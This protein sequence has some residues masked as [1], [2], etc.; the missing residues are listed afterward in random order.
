MTPQ[1]TQPDL[2]LTGV[3]KAA[4]FL[5][6]IG[7]QISADV[8]RRLSPEEI[9]SIGM[10]ISA[11]GGVPP[12]QMLHVFREFEDLTATSKLFAQGGPGSARRLLEQAV[13]SESANALLKIDPHHPRGAAGNEKTNPGPLDDTD[14]QELAK[15]L[16]E[17]NPQTLALI[18]SNLAP[19]QAGPLLASLPPD[20]QPQVALRIALMDRIAP[21]VF[22][23]IAD[24]IRL[25]LK[26]ATQLNRSNGAR[27]L[28]SILN[29][30]DG[31]MADTVLSA[32]ESENQTTVTAVR[33]LMFVFDDVIG[34][35]KEGIKALLGKVDR[36]VLTIALKGT[37]EKIRT[38]FTQ[39]MSQ[40]SS[41]MLLED[42]EALGPIRIRDVSGAQQSVVA[43][44]RQLQKDGV[45]A[46]SQG[47]GGDE[48]VV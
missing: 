11:L 34:I 27:A 37:S 48:Y 15:V 40:R 13:G 14:P 17:E 28:A 22:R 25:R 6:G 16:R 32:I 47:G 35:D 10:E 19:A 7:D 2:N 23:R 20:V 33:D 12:A 26:A 29:Y 3:R 21:E 31:D 45:I 46:S 24:A 30:V 43:V 42:M 41:E 9:R 8:I 39:C 4:V 18:L 1:L 5:L 36:K 38:H 44:I